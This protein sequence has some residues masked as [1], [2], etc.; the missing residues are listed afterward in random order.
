R[1]VAAAGARP[2]AAGP[3]LRGGSD[4]AL[5]DAVPAGPGQRARGQGPQGPEPPHARL[6]RLGPAGPL[7]D[8]PPLYDLAPALRLMLLGV[9]VALG[10]LAWVWLRNARAEPAQRLAALTLLTLCLTF[11]LV[12]VGAFTRLTDSGLGCPDW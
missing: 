4:G 1:A 3:P 7:M 12:L 9:A 8:A 5:D 11:D 2:G 10:P 6:G